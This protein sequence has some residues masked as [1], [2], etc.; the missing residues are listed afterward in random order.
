MI[1]RGT[2]LLLIAGVTGIAGT[3]AF[4]DD[5]PDQP[6]ERTAAER[7]QDRNQAVESYMERL[8]LKRLLAEHLEQQLA[9]APKDQRSGPAERLSK[10]YVELITSASGV[11]AAP[12]RRRWED[13]ARALLAQVPEAD[14]FDLRLSLGRAVYQQAEEIAERQRLRL[15]TPEEAA[16]AE[17]TFRTLASQFNEIAVKAH[18]RVDQLER[19]EQ[20]GDASEKL[21]SELSDARRQRSLAFY[22]E[23]WARTYL[24]Q[25]TRSEQPAVEAMRAFGWLLNSSGGKPA[26]LDR[27]SP[28]MLQ[29]EHIARAVIACGLCAG[30]RGADVEALRWLDFVA[31]AEQTPAVVREQLPTRRMMILAQAKR[32]ADLELL[33]RRTR[34]ADRTGGGPGLKPLPPLLARL[35][36]VCT[37]EADRRN[38]G[39]QIEELAKIAMQD[40]VTQKEVTQVLDLVKRYGTAPLGE[41]GFIVHYVRALQAYDE[42]RSTHE[43]ASASAEEPTTDAAAANQY[44]AAAGMF[45]AAARESDAESFP[46]ERARAGVMQGRSL[47]FAGDL[48]PAADAF[49][50]AHAAAGKSPA[51]EEPLY[52]GVLALERAAKLDTATNSN[53]RERLNQAVA[54]FLQTYPD[55]E[56]APRLTLM[57]ISMGALND[58]DALKVLSNV[59]KESPVYEAARRQL[60]R[61]LY[62]KF[63]IA[64]GQDRDFAAQRFVAVGEDVLAADRKVAMDGSATDAKAAV[65]RVVV[66]A[67][68]LLDALLGTSAPDVARAEAVMKLLSGV[69]TYNSYDLTPHRAELAFRELQIALARGDD[70]QIENAS[71]MLSQATDATAQFHAAGERL[72]YRHYQQQLQSNASA[73]PELAA[74]VIKFGTRV[75]DRIGSD[76]AQLRDPSVAAVYSGVSE[77][78]AQRAMTTGDA[79][80]RELSMRLDRAILGVQPSAEPVLRRLAGTSEAAQDF[81]LAISCWRRI[82]ESS[83]QGSDIALEAR[84]HTIRIMGKI[85]PAKARA[86]LS[87]HLILYPDGGPAPWGAKIVA[88]GTD[89]PTVPAAV[90]SAATPT[91]PAPTSAPSAPPTQSP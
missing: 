85:D 36:A 19:I 72:L 8:G 43:K 51:G 88:L 82:L 45:Q 23:G 89:L 35:L 6:A 55:S 2:M 39:P 42:A 13:K 50:A 76:P 80:M 49:L 12:E 15:A 84:F 47:F 10:L 11:Q 41:T 26:T 91:A 56:H 86:A 58:D 53:V 46:L 31:E 68:Q 14:S 60:A 78:A 90:P 29:Y 25:L 73:N 59:S 28:A 64:R 3:A 69:A 67:R 1:R 32:W 63:R 33:V 22:Y 74:K 77:A 9:K 61:I 65:E 40:L 87:E 44:R 34:K 54:V 83:P 62:A 30:Q 66:R 17:Q 81:N 21:I 48:M 70:G 38:A 5:P 20:Q 27:L 24:A 16:E 71:M 7:A 75:V 18:R 37:L 4:G 79:A 57:Q 52:L